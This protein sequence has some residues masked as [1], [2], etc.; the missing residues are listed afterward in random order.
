MTGFKLV[1][2]PPATLSPAVRIS[3]HCHER[4]LV[5]TAQGRGGRTL[6]LIALEILDFIRY[7][8]IL[9]SSS[10]RRCRWHLSQ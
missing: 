8:A 5:A 6:H 4:L 10:I 9:L 2:S 7:S 1:L 3:R